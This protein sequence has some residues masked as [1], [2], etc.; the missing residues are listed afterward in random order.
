[1]K[2][3]KQFFFYGYNG[4]LK[5]LI[6]QPFKRP[7]VELDG[8]QQMLTNEVWALANNGASVNDVKDY[9]QVAYETWG[10]FGYLGDIIAFKA[11][12]FGDTDYYFLDYI[13]RLATIKPGL[14]A[15]LLMLVRTNSGNFFVGIK[16][17]NNPGQG[18]LALPGGFVDVNGY[19]LDTPIETVIHEAE[20]EIGLKIRTVNDI[21]L[22][23]YLP[24]KSYVLVD[25]KGKDLDGELIP[26]GI[27]PT[28]DNE[29]LSSTHT[30]RVYTTTVFSLMLDATSTDLDEARINEWLKAGD[31]AAD[32]V[33]VSINKN[34]KLE[35]GLDH[36]QKVFDALMKNLA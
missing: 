29:E 2:T 12:T 23:A 18:K 7:L 6:E 27:F 17:K 31:D 20:E 33:I 19:H 36:H 16:R 25:Y 9:L 1:M 34:T 30:K 22:D 28:G 15:D 14:A 26:L 32:L 24:I 11:V 4:E 21:D 8:D 35:F 5:D 10:R 3:A 13:G